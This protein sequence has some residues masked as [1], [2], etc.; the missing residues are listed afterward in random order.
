[1]YKQKFFHV[2]NDSVLVFNF[3]GFPPVTIVIEIRSSIKFG[4]DKNECP[5]E[6]ND[7]SH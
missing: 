3:L 6:R 5:W 1:M 2:I 4:G 7:S